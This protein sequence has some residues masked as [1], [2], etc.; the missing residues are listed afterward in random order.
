[1]PISIPG[2]RKETSG[3]L[4]LSITILANS[5]QDWPNSESILE[6]AESYRPNTFY[7]EDGQRLLK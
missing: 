4:P 3:K 7:K 5:L 6:L 1:M 2:S